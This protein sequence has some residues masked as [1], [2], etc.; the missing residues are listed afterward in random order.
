M[1]GSKRTKQEI[2]EYLK[3]T[4]VEGLNTLLEFKQIENL[5]II[6]IIYNILYNNYNPNK[7]LEYIVEK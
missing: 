1:I 3:T 4:T 6:E 5:K 2:E 7:L